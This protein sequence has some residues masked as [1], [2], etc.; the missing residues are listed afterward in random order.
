MARFRSF[1]FSLFM[2]L[3]ALVIGTL[4]APALLRREWA[5]R[6]AKFWIDVCLWGLKVICGIDARVTGQENLDVR[7]ALIAAKHQSMWETIFLAR[8]L[9]SA[10]FVL[11][12]ELR[13]VPI[14][15]WWCHRL[16]FVFID[17][18]AG[19]KALRS[20]LTQAQE[21]FDQ[22]ASHLII[23]PEG[24]RT[25]PYETVAYQSGVAA[26]AK[27]LGVP[28]IPVSHNSGSFWRH[29]EKRMVPGTIDLVA[30]PP[31]SSEMPRPAFLKTLQNQIDV[32]ATRLADL[33]TGNEKRAKAIEDPM[34]D[35]PARAKK[36]Y[37]FIPLALIAI[38]F[39][40]YSVVWRI[41]AGVMEREIDA[42]IEEE[43]AEGRVVTYQDRS[44]RG[45]PFTLRAQI[46]HF[47]WSEPGVWEWSGETLHIV[48][49]PYDV[50]RLIF[51]PRDA[52]RV[53]YEGEPYDITPSDLR[54]GLRED[55]INVEGSDISATG[56]DRTVS[57]GNIKA[58]FIANNEETWILGAALRGLRFVDQEERQLDSPYWNIAAS[59]SSIP[60]TPVTIDATELALTTPEAISPTQL[61]LSGTIGLDANNR[62]EG[63]ISLRLQNLDT[64]MLLLETY[65]TMG[66]TDLAQARETLRAMPASAAQELPLD[67]AFENGEAHLKTMFGSLVLGEAPCLASC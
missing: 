54:V 23:F 37:L 2:A 38:V 43:R 30:F 20:M 66:S 11:K 45:Y 64:V 41:G 26:L 44:I 8:F 7:P 18:K 16:G 5:L 46:K 49:L 25:A 10:R 53:I 40:I 57:L 50:S 27:S 35:K 36:R 15:G 21:A 61:G 29:H 28:T 55:Q 67:I 19:A 17:R 56:Q 32:E 9:P 22:G 65:G 63:E 59:G 60:G 62:A 51:A 34:S 3:A 1:A 13:A 12:K 14:F 4:G 33:A 48:T 47:N 31:V 39:V 6:V 42:F 24:T 52:Q 58:N